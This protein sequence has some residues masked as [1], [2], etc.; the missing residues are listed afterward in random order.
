[1]G[2]LLDDRAPADAT[3]PSLCLMRPWAGSA[4]LAW[5]AAIG[6]TTA[7]MWPEL[8][9][10]EIPL[11][12]LQALSA[13]TVGWPLA[14]IA[15]AMAVFLSVPCFLSRDRLLICAGVAMCLFAVLVVYVSP[16]FAG[17]FGFI[18][19]NIIRETKRPQPSSGSAR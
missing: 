15:F 16:V 8:F 18:A 17:I 13:R 1:M 10:A 3:S 6:A 7:V 5:L 12:G 9:G 11:P 4:P 2:S 19:G 14:I